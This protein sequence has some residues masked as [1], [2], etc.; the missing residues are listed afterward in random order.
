[1]E[2]ASRNG[3][4]DPARHRGPPLLLVATIHLLLFLAA[5][6]VPAAM[7]AGHIPS[8]FVDAETSA[9]YFVDHAQ[10]TRIAAFLLLGSAIPFGI[11]A[12][13]AT[14]RVQFLGIKVVAGL[15]IALFGGFAAAILLALSSFVQWALASCALYLSAGTTHVLHL[16]MFATGGPGYVVP[17][18]LFVAGISV[19]S[20]IQGFSP[21]WL[22]F[23]GLAIA[24]AAELSSLVL[25]LP[26]VAPLLPIARFLG[27]AWMLCVAAYLPRSRRAAAAREDLGRSAPQGLAQ[28]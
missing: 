27:L 14:S 17:F 9:R 23:A 3:S 10:S 28:T 12:A 22:M 11:F 24:L 8:P 21:R 25:V 26:A 7:G 20:G 16:L 6:V 5:L 1:M 15:N 18:G 19:T 4:S 13:S 2:S